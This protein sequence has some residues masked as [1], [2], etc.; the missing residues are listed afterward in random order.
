MAAKPR[1]PAFITVTGVEAP[2]LAVSSSN[3]ATRKSKSKSKPDAE[4]EAE[5]VE[6][7]GGGEDSKDEMKRASTKPLAKEKSAKKPRVKAF[8]QEEP[9]MSV[10]EVATMFQ[11]VD[12]SLVLWPEKLINSKEVVVTTTI[13]T[14]AVLAEVTTV[15]AETLTAV[16]SKLH[17]FEQ[18][19]EPENRKLAQ[20][21]TMCTT[22]LLY[23]ELQQFVQ[24]TNMLAGTTLDEQWKE[25][26]TMHTHLCK[27]TQLYKWL[28]LGRL[29]CH[30]P[31]LQY[32]AVLTTH[33]T[34]RKT[35]KWLGKVMPLVQAF[36]EM[37]PADSRVNSG[38]YDLHTDGFTVL[39]MVANLIAE[40]EALPMGQLVEQTQTRSPVAMKSEMMD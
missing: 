14:P 12:D 35:V 39:Q 11:E 1:A 26:R 33:N 23:L 6:D 15:T 10:D 37:I 36:A 5:A 3:E 4:A 24:A 9:D 30:C 25:M 21:G 27:K 31:N 8:D 38:P 29:V 16:C 34:F 2:A 17:S 22:A 32:Q 20:C 18:G 19:G 28:E 40:M 7:A 13:K